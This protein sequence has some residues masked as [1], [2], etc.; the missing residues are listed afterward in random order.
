M[1]MLQIKFLNKWSKLLTELEV[2][3]VKF[4]YF[5]KDTGLRMETEVIDWGK[6]LGNHILDKVL[7]SRPR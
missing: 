5:V 6:I 4:V 1:H 7:A 3:I 2:K